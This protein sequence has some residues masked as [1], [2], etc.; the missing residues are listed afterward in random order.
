VAWFCAIF[1]GETFIVSLFEVGLKL[2]NNVS[3]FIFLGA[4][5]FDEAEAINGILI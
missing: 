4:R 2:S 1:T 3:V 5:S